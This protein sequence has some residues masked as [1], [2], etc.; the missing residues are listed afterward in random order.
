[1]E[2][3]DREY[4]GCRKDV[5]KNVRWR[6]AVMNRHNRKTSCGRVMVMVDARHS[7]V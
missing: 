3:S 7:V 5:I 4:V 1:M 6:D 2:A